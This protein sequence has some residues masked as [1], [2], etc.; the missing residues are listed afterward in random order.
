MCRSIKKFADPEPLRPLGT[1]LFVGLRAAD[2]ALQ[3]SIFQ[4]G[5][6]NNL[7]TALGG[8]TIPFVTPRDP[9]LAYFGLAPYPA[10]ITGLA[11]GSSIKHVVWQLGISEQEMKPGAAVVISASN[12][13][14]SSANTLLSIWALSS[15]APQ[16][17]TQSASLSDV[18]TSS[19]IL[20]LGLGL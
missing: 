7:I 19:P 4:Q 15:A 12:T 9:A 5:W 3:Y 20:M 16:M 18:V 11:L 10:L 14:F 8:A 17:A 2:T 1:A 6:G 13:V